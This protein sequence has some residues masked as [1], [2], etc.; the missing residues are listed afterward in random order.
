VLAAAVTMMLA[1]DAPAASCR[2]GCAEAA[3][4]C[5]RTSRRA[6]PTCTQPDRAA[7]KECR[8]RS[9]LLAKAGKRSCRGYRGSCRRCCR[10]GG[11]DCT[12]T[13]DAGV[14]TLDAAGGT[15]AVRGFDGGTLELVMPPGALAQPTEI[16][17]APLPADA[18]APVRFRIRPA[19]LPLAAAATLRFTSGTELP[20]RSVLRW[21]IGDERYALPTTQD[22]RT[23]LAELV[24]LGYT[25]G[26]SAPQRAPARSVAQPGTAADPPAELDVASL[27]C[28][29]ELAVIQL[30]LAGA[31]AQNDIARAQ[32]EFDRAQAVVEACNLRQVAA[33]TARACEAHQAA[34]LTAQAIAA[35]GYQ[36]FR[37]LVTP[38]ML[39][40]ANVQLTGA[41]CP[42][43]PFDA[44]VQAKLEQFLDFIAADYA[45]PDFAADFG[46]AAAELRRLFDYAAGCRRL[47]L[48]PTCERFDDELIPT[49]LD[50]LRAAA[51]RECRDRNDLLLLAQMYVQELPRPV[52]QPQSA[53]RAHAAVTTGPYL[54][55]GRF[56]FEDVERDLA[57]CRS[58]LT[59]RVFDD[60]DDVP[61]ELTERRVDLPA[62]PEP[63]QHATT[64]EVSAP[65][66]GSVTVEGAVRTLTCPDGS[67]SAD[68][69]VARV[70]GVQLAAR[71]A[72]GASFALATQPLDVVVDAVRGSAV[73]ADASE[74]TVELFREGPAC[75]GVF[76]SP[77]L[78]YAIRVRIDDEC[79]F[80]PNALPPG[81]YAVSCESCTVA[82]TV[83][84]C[85]C[86]R[87]D[88][89]FQSTQIDVANC[90]TDR[91][92]SN[93]D[94][95][96]R[97]AACS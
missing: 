66:D 54:T 30:A 5:V 41:E 93:D 2:Q 49:I 11:T 9:R 8:V 33:L 69:L 74:F 88:G 43:T 42:A 77:L 15:V 28:D 20:T 59:V 70:N 87:I 68:A 32:A 65:P 22:R 63:G 21:R 58:S 97:C 75:G 76:T 72:D 13:P 37:D 80:P 67:G 17:L 85:S 92:V 94:G 55:F 27:D 23:L 24:T 40:Q 45:R 1:A 7:R 36:A 90:R 19:G 61:H 46:V 62:S 96:L 14:A 73:A 60:A 83:L 89:E 10:T 57:H 3:T 91:D 44:V 50:R 18:D 64:A 39:T 78:L 25:F 82:G 4:A 48:E 51:Y 53:G 35:D 81:S 52:I 34:L 26:A 29:F 31:V 12:T 71:P 38:V 79:G 84:G 47:G 95:V 6:R 16:R 86:R 56:T